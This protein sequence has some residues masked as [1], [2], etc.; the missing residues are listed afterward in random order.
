MQLIIKKRRRFYRH[1]KTCVENCHFLFFFPPPP[2]P[3][4]IITNSRGKN[5]YKIKTSRH[6]KYYK[7]LYRKHNR[8]KVS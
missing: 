5:K 1:A 6:E 8:N 3:P 2:P 7:I 4:T